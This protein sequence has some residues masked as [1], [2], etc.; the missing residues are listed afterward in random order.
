MTKKTAMMILFLAAFVTLPLWAQSTTLVETKVPFAFTVGKATLPAGNYE[1]SVATTDNM[2]WEIRSRD[3][4]HS[5]AFLTEPGTTEKMAPSTDVTF[6]EVN[7][8]NYL[9]AIEI[10][11]ETGNWT[12]PLHELNL[13]KV[14]HSTKHLHG[15]HHKHA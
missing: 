13:N 11:G 8:K 6:V 3:G 9:S 1:L 5:A 2:Q 14:Q 7:G 10:E 12:V 4:K 15:L